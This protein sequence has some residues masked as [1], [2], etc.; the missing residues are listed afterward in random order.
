MRF[1]EEEGSPSTSYQKRRRPENPRSPHRSTMPTF[2][3]EGERYSNEEKRCKETP[4]GFQDGEE[5][6]YTS[7]HHK[8]KENVNLVS[9][10]KRSPFSPSAAK[11]LVSREEALA[12]LQGSLELL[13][14][15]DPCMNHEM[16]EEEKKDSGAGI[17]EEM[18]PSFL[19]AVGGIIDLDGGTLVFCQEV[20]TYQLIQGRHKISAHNYFKIHA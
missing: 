8:A 10:G 17:L 13:T 5:E 1:Q 11:V 12:S 14:Y 19:P 18:R 9:L 7:Y 3:E 2:F 6:I 15:G 4:K 20:P 16:H